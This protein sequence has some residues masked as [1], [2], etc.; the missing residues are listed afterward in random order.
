MDL[1]FL[2]K[3]FNVLSNRNSLTEY[4]DNR[5]ITRSLEPQPTVDPS[6]NGKSVIHQHAAKWAGSHYDWRLG[7]AGVLK[8]FMTRRIPDVGES[9]LAMATEDYPASYLTFS[10]S[11]DEGHY[12]AGRVSVHDLGR[13]S[14]LAITPELVTFELRGGKISGKFSLSAIAHDKYMMKREAL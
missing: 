9:T 1:Q 7:H 2:L 5:D 14:N 11:I 8:S 3:V 13:V 6:V 10:G 12:G 4:M